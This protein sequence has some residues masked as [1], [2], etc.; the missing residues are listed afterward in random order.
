VSER[1]FVNPHQ[2][3]TLQTAAFLAY[4]SAVFDLLAVGAFGPIMLAFAGGLVVGGYGIANEDR[5]G[6]TIAVAV[7]VL[8]VGWLV[9]AFGGSVLAFPTILT[10]MFDGALVALLAHPLSRD[11]QRIW[12]K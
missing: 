2:P 7:A 6:Y 8:R 3:Q 9:A 10:L 5:R 12:F 4:F 1:R 11:Y